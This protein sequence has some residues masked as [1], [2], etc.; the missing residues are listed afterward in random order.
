MQKEKEDEEFKDDAPLTQYAYYEE[1]GETDARLERTRKRVEQVVRTTVGS[2]ADQLIIAQS[3][4]LT[5]VVGHR[6][7]R[8]LGSNSLGGARVI[9]LLYFKAKG[10]DGALV[11][12]WPIA[13]FYEEVYTAWYLYYWTICEMASFVDFP[14]T[15]P[16]PQ[17]PGP[18]I[19]VGPQMYLDLPS[20]AL[21]M[22]AIIE[23]SRVAEET[24]VR[25]VQI[26]SKQQHAAF[27][28]HLDEISATLNTLRWNIYD[29]VSDLDNIVI[30]LTGK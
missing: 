25:H 11:V 2:I 6:D 4:F 22:E 14:T 20:L 1:G 12:D 7:P 17:Y 5:R 10:G 13:K 8:Y 15:S 28:R 30:N 27:E 3:L 29:L 24:Q 16:L 9:D 19:K 26:Y 21:R 18:V 23:L